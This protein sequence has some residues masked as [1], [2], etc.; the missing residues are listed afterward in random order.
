MK[1]TDLGVKEGQNKVCFWHKNKMS[2][3]NCALMLMFTM[4]LGCRLCLRP[5][6]PTV[7]ALWASDY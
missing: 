2:F 5:H 3:A 7:A 6:L 4:A 1:T